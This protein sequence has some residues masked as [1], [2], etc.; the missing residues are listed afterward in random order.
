MLR[1]V[2][3]LF[4]TFLSQHAYDKTVPES[5]LEPN[6]NP[7]LKPNQEPEVLEPNA[8]PEEEVDP[9][10]MLA[11]LPKASNRKD[12]FNPSLSPIREVLRKQ[13]TKNQKHIDLSCALSN[14]SYCP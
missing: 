6:P 5:E 12:R 8:Q 1:K 10:A 13:E 9:I 3:S 4:F 2:F 14:L 7:V 11:A